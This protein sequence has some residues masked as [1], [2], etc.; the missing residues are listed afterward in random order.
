MKFFS[1]FF[2]FYFFFFFNFKKHSAFQIEILSAFTFEMYLKSTDKKEDKKKHDK[3]FVYQA[4]IM[5]MG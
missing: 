2:D 1:I 5:G 3:N 4:F